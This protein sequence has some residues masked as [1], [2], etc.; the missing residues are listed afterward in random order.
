M[1][2]E[3]KLRGVQ[4][5]VL[6]RDAVGASWAGYY[7][8]LILHTGKH[9]SH[10]PGMVMPE[11]MPL[12][13]PRD[14]FVR[15]LKT[16]A[17]RFELPIRP[18]TSVV[19][20]R[21]GDSGWL[22][23]TGD[24][25]LS[26]RTLVVAT[27][28]A[29]NPCRAQLEGED[30]FGG[31]ILHSSEYRDPAPFVGRKV[32]VVG[33]GNSAGEIA[34]ELGEARAETAVSVRSGAHVMPLKILGVPS[35]YWS[36]LLGKLPDPLPGVIAGAANRALRLIRG[37]PPVPVPDWPVLAKPP[38][39]GDSLPA[40][41]RSGTVTLRGEVVRV[42]AGAVHFRDGSEE[43]FDVVLLATGYRPAVGFLKGLV[44]LDAEGFP[45]RDGVQSLDQPDLYF[46]GHVYGPTGAIHTIRRDAP[47]AARAVAEST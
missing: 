27:G 34:G 41:I 47:R 38:L 29:S 30:H 23:D 13:P 15:Y 17:A 21:R 19:S 6:E 35:Q 16:Y 43:R 5:V 8:S 45:Q 3:L 31:T 25:T 9:L 36:V 40:A 28:I 14:H 26:A 11:D 20:A 2:R 33:V 32:L 24:E 4:H 39:I 7:R 22:V 18:G 37:R 1:S 10:L 12:F 46:V 44:R 42:S